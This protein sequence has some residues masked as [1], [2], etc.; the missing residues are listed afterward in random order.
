MINDSYYPGLSLEDW[1]P[2]VL[3]NSGELVDQELADKLQACI[4]YELPGKQ[5]CFREGFWG[6]LSDEQ[7]KTT[8]N[9]GRIVKRDPDVTATYFLHNKCMEKIKNIA[10]KSDR[11]RAW[12][13]CIEEEIGKEMKLDEISESWNIG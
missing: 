3:D 9:G 8:C 1:L 5:A 6:P 10:D 12:T 7:Q 4:C 2:E 13:E 11:V